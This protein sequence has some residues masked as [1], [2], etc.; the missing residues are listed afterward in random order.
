MSWE[1]YARDGR[2]GI[3]IAT[4]GRLHIITP[5]TFPT[6]ASRH[7]I[8]LP[9]D[10]LNHTLHS[11]DRD[12]ITHHFSRRRTP[13][14]TTRLDGRAKK[15]PASMDR[16]HS[17]PGTT[18]EHLPRKE[19]PPLSTSSPPVLTSRVQSIAHWGSTR[20][21]GRGL[22]ALSGKGLIHQIT[23]KPG[24]EYI[25]HPSAVIAYSLMQH[26]PQPFRFKSTSLRMQIPNPLSR[27]PDTRFW[28]T[29]REST[30]W[31]FLRNTAFT[32]RTWARRGIWG[33]RVRYPSP[34]LLFSLTHHEPF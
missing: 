16:Q 24:E 7:S 23:L 12:E 8:P 34:S 25:V 26:A 33:D 4:A 15:L 21:T 11:S 19:S 3:L 13:R 22:V 17:Q 31:T 1:Y 5:R 9:K 27:L 18:P 2:S 6:S 20:L 29:M 14:R 30:L 28:R 10:L 32:I